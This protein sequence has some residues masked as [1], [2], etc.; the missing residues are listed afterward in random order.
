MP[1]QPK[2]DK[3]Q[4]LNISERAEMFQAVVEMGEVGILVLREHNHIEFANKMA[5]HI[6]GYKTGDLL[7]KDFCDFLDQENREIFKTLRK[8]CD[9]YATKVCQTIEIITASSELAVN[10]MCCASHA[11]GRSGE[12]KLFVYLRDISLQQKL[13]EELA[14]TW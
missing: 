11:T 2:E 8:D 4:K 10:E 14:K 7:G 3:A 5:S 1:T 12:R 6:M 13:T 9:T